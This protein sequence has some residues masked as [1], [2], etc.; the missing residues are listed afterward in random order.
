MRPV[1]DVE[2]ARPPDG[3]RRKDVSA[4]LGIPREGPAPAVGHDPDVHHR[5]L[6]GRG[7]VHPGRHGLRRRPA[8][9]RPGQEGGPLLH[10]GAPLLPGPDPGPA[11]HVLSGHRLFCRN[12]RHHGLHLCHHDPPDL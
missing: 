3:H 5:D 6:S 11:G 8:G 4:G 10:P 12:G 9:T 1:P 2:P 7:A